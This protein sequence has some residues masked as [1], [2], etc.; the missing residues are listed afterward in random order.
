MNMFGLALRKPT[1]WE[2][3]LTAAGCTLL[4]V[5]TLVVCLAFGYA[6]D[7]TTKVVF[8]VSLAWGSLCN[9][10]GIRVLE[11]ERHILLLVGG[12]A[13]LNL[14]ALGLIDAMTT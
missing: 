13:F 10:L 11:G 12:C 7:T 8:S 5:V 1:F 3:T 2:I 6:P 4:L 9:V 14:I